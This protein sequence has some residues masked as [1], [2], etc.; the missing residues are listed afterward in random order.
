[1]IESSLFIRIPTPSHPVLDDESAEVSEATSRSGRLPPEAHPP[2]PELLLLPMPLPHDVS[3]VKV[4]GCLVMGKERRVL[5][6][7]F[8]DGDDK[9]SDLDDAHDVAGS[10][11]LPFPPEEWP[12][13]LTSA[14]WSCGEPPMWMCGCVSACSGCSPPLSGVSMYSLR[15][16]STSGRGCVREITSAGVA[17]AVITAGSLVATNRGIRTGRLGALRP[18]LDMRM[19]LPGRC[20][21][22]GSMGGRGNRLDEVLSSSISGL[23][24]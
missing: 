9:G 24:R 8:R 22:T 15:M 3:L 13:G 18:E 7:R 1:M 2:G 6:I 23:R 19:A 4:S 10:V 16:R 20:I 5:C 12:S 21:R 17:A 14:K 11:L